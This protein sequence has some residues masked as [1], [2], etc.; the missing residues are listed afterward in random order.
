[1]SQT[2]AQVVEHVKQLSLDEKQELQEL[3]RKF[4]IEERRQEILEN[5]KAGIEEWRERKLTAFADIDK[6]RDSL[7]NS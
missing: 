3:L 2:F 7:S 1:M 5:S 6:L 4:L